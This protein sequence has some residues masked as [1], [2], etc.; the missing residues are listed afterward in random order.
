MG[1]FSDCFEKVMGLVET[2]MDGEMR[3]EVLPEAK[4]LCPVKTGALRDSLESGV[5]RDGTRVTAYIETDKSYAPFQEFGSHAY[6]GK[7][8]M[9]RG[10]ERFDLGRVA[11]RMKGGD[12]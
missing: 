1:M 4:R 3:E 11:K 7:A 6:P 2:A 8:F 10:L 12:E 9:R 5:E